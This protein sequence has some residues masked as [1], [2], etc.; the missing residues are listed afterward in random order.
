LID[1]KVTIADAAMA[2]VLTMLR[3][4]RL[5]FK[6][7]SRVSLLIRHPSVSTDHATSRSPA[8]SNA[9]TTIAVMKNYARSIYVSIITP[10]NDN[11]FGIPAIRLLDMR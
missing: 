9:K 2:P 7:K 5:A 8:R 6:L 3:R 1:A 4:V 10:A 11:A